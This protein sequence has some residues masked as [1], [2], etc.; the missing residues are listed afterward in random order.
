MNDALASK[1]VQR[2]V[3][4]PLLLDV[5]QDFLGV[6]PILRTVDVWVSLPS[7]GVA[8]SSFS[9]NAW[10]IDFNTVRG[11]KVFVVLTSLSEGAGGHLFIPETKDSFGLLAD[12]Q[13]SD[14]VRDQK[15][16]H[17]YERTRYAYDKKFVIP[18]VQT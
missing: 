17:F 4:D 15:L 10:H 13:F 9:F 2:L 11:L 7:S 16:S 6:P 14:G 8:N 18:Y 12:R 3:T 5:V 1:H